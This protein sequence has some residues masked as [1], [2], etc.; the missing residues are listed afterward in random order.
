MN[1]EQPYLINTAHGPLVSTP[2]TQEANDIGMFLRRNLTADE[3]FGLWK[4][5]FDEL[6]RAG[7][8]S[9]RMMSIGLHPH[10]IGRAFRARAIREFLDY[11]KKFDGV[12]W[13][14]REEIA[15]WYLQNHKSHI[16]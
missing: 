14:T 4:D 8:K 12:W 5:E 10:I 1:D 2:Y 15:D 11:A 7:E 13:A 6:Y 9:G 3:A 16:S